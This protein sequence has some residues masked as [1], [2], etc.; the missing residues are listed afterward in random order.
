MGRGSF[1]K[2]NLALHKLS[3]KVVAVKSINVKLENDKNYEKV[4]REVDIMT[5]LRHKNVVKFFE[6]LNTESHHLIFMEVCQGGDL[7]NYVRKRKFLGEDLAKY[8]FRQIIMGIGYIHSKK[9]VHRDIKLENILI[10][11]EGV[12]KIADFGIS[13]KLED[14]AV[15]IKN[16]YAG[17]LAYMAPE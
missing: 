12:V 4:T 6:Q 1:G 8:L 3:R 10:D 9:V 13:R 7:L 2:V 5:L 11:N 15:K 16:D 14:G 17:T